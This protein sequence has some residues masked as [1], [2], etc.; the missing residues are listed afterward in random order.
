MPQIPIQKS[1]VI[2]KLWVR[3]HAI[4]GSKWL[5]AYGPEDSSGTWA[6]VLGE[7][8]PEQLGAGVRA[9]LDREDKEWPPT[10]AEFRDLCRNSDSESI[11]TLA[12]Q[13]ISS[14]ERQTLSRKEIEKLAAQNLSRARAILCGQRNPTGQEQITLDRLG[15]SHQQ[16]QLLEAP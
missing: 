14:F 7:F 15:F 9:C 12:V 10:L 16:K 6:E 8:M 1:T 4:Y 11:K 13:L 5:A 3:L 2:S